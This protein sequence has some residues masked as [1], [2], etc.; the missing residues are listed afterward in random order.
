[1]GLGVVALAGAYLL[2]TSRT[3]GAGVAS[4]AAATLPQAGTSGSTTGITVQGTGKVTGTPDTLLLSMSVSVTG[5]TVS[6]AMGSANAKASAVQK[7]LLAHGVA[8]ADL[9][10]SNLSIQANYSSSGTKVTG[11]QVSEGVSATLRDLRTA[12]AAVSAAADAGGDSTRVDGIS[13]DLGET[14]DL[15]SAARDSAFAQ[16]KSKA[17][18]YAKAAGVG[19]GK[20]LSIDETT[21][22]SEPS[23]AMPMAARADM[24]SVPIQ[25]GSQDVAV[26]VTV[27]FAIS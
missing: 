15:V 7:S 10:T 26:T 17:A 6:A 21:Q 20:V 14:G 27:V 25:A 5:D 3:P 13:L 16:A 22:P 2:G 1:M 8:K 9:Q 4:A 11:Y 12:G 23:Y 19:L 24:K 18:Q